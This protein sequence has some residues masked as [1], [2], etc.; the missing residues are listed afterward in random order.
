MRQELAFLGGLGLGAGLMYLL[1]PQTGRRRRALARDQFV[2]AVNQLD[3]CIDATSRDVMHRLRGVVAESRSMFDSEPVDDAVLVDRIRSKLGRIVSHPHAIQV[4]AQDGRVTLNG[5]ILEHELPCL[6]R[7][8]SSMHGVQNVEDR[9]DVRHEAGDTPS[10][11]GGIPRPG[12]QANWA[13]A[14]RL[15]AGTIG[16]ALVGYGLTRSFPTACILGT[17]GLA[18]L[19]RAITNKE[20]RLLL[21]I[22]CNARAVEMNKTIN[23]NAPVEEV[24]HAFAR[25]ENFPRFMGHLREVRDLGGGRSHWVAAGPGGIR[26][27][28][29]AVLTRFEANRLIAWRSE[30]GSTIANAGL[31]RFQP[32]DRQGTRVD[33]HMAYTPPAGLLGHFAALLFGADPKS[34]MNEDLVRIKSLLEEGKASAP[35]KQVER[36]EM[37][38][39]RP[40]ELVG[41]ER[42]SPAF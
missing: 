29:D 19:G 2:S 16:T 17:A 5:T 36:H 42:N 3:D 32:N 37:E 12:E 4:L 18:L 40:S 24:F 39:G 23:I 10:L 22:G 7:T 25:Y 33:I 13:P 26:A 30:P 6:M 34:A 31:I 8:I 9:L 41:A 11:Q 27:S 15:L 1:D 20:M 28:W 38:Q 21:G 35:G 14:T